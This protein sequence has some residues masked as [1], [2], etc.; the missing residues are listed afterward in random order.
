MCI[1]NPANKVTACPC[2]KYADTIKSFMVKLKKEREK[3][4]ENVLVL[5]PIRLGVL[6]VAV[7]WYARKSPNG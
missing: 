4:D 2:K 7:L 1:Q 3:S 6:R 5:Y